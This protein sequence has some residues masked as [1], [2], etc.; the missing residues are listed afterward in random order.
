MAIPPRSNLNDPELTTLLFAAIVRK[1]GGTVE[2][3]QADVDAVAYNRLKEVV[4]EDGSL[5]FQ[6]IE[7]GRAL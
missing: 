2:I 1:L 3:T 5:A 6:L 4:R 7:R